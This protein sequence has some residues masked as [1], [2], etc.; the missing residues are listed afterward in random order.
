MKVDFMSFCT[1]PAEDFF[2]ASIPYYS[3]YKSSASP[4]DKK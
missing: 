3:P 2:G 1:N 4:V